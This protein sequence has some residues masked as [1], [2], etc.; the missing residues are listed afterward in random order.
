MSVL[1]PSDSS[2]N[3]AGPRGRTVIT[4]RPWESGVNDLSL[5]DKVQSFEGR[6]HKTA[7]QWVPGVVLAAVEDESTIDFAY[8]DL[9]DALGKSGLSYGI[10]LTLPGVRWVKRPTVAELAKSRVKVE[11]ADGWAGYDSARH[12]PAEVR[13]YDVGS[14][15]LKALGRASRERLEKKLPVQRK[16]RLQTC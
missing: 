10:L 5:I 14:K 3:R 8:E 9:S 16:V 7:L 4:P 11:V 15:R 1:H 2:P 6:I 12:P 13:L